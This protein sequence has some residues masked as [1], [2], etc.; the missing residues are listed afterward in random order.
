LSFMRR[1]SSV[2]LSDQHEIGWATPARPMC[3]KCCR[4]FRSPTAWRRKC[5]GMPKIGPAIIP[6][7]TA[8]RHNIAVFA[9]AGKKAGLLAICLRCAAYSQHHVCNLRK[10][11]PGSLGT[12]SSALRR[13][14]RGLHPTDKHSYIQAAVRPWPYVRSTCLPAAVPA[15]YVAA[16]AQARRADVPPAEVANAAHLP[17]AVEPVLPHDVPLGAHGEGDPPFGDPSDVP[18][19]W[20]LQALANWFGD[21]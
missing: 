6:E 10:Q 12:R 4:F 21:N 9:I 1:H 2:P 18:E 13:V 19:E 16:A 20:D 7:A 8:N 15:G 17:S 14:L 11:C 3:T 5:S